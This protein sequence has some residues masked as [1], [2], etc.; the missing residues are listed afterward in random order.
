M[1]SVLHSGRLWRRGSCYS[2]WRRARALVFERLCFAHRA[3]SAALA[4]SLLKLVARTLAAPVPALPPS[5]PSATAAGFLL[6]VTPELALEP[7]WKV[8]I[9]A[10]AIR[11]E[12]G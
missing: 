11:V 3:L 8:C 9:F 12:V 10:S 4:D 6:T 7:F 5:F 1:A 2:F